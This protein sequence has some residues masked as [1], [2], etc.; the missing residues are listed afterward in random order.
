MYLADN[1]VFLR[2][3]WGL[4]QSEAASTVAISRPS[5]AAYEKGGE[6]GNANPTIE[7]VAALASF[8]KVSIDML[9]YRQLRALPIEQ[10][11][12]IIE[13]YNLLRNGQ[14][15]T[16][17]DLVRTVGMDNEENIELV[18][19]TAMMGYCSG[20]Y[21]DLEFIAELPTFRLPFLPNSRKYRMFPTKGDS[22]MPIPSGSFVIGEYIEKWGSVKDGTGVIVISKE[23][24]VLKKIVNELASKG[25][26]ILHS[27]NPSYGPYEMQYDDIL[28]LWKY[29]SYI[30]RDFPDPEPSLGTILSEMRRINAG[31]ADLQSGQEKLLERVQK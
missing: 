8:Y 23:G 21:A 22:M 19:I 16:T 29:E 13:N 25:R 27:L 2:D 9:L 24:I 18:P 17:R 31:V 12:Q 1:L 7:N 4:S 30:S 3:Y 15:P 11:D 5:L 28:Q 14:F 26:L 10:I 20:G 6:K